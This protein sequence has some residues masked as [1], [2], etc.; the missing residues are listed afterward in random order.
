VDHLFSGYHYS[1]AGN[2]VVARVLEQRLVTP[3][4]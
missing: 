4:S 1:G 3:G 2:A